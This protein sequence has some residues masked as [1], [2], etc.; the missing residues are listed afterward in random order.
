MNATTC[1]NISRCPGHVSADF[2]QTSGDSDKLIRHPTAPCVGVLASSVQVQDG[3]RMPCTNEGKPITSTT[4]SLAVPTAAVLP[5]DGHHWASKHLVW[6][7]LCPC[8]AAS[9]FHIAINRTMRTWCRPKVVDLRRSDS[10]TDGMKVH[11]Q[12]HSSIIQPTQMVCTYIIHTVHA[13]SHR[14]YHK[15]T[16]KKCK[17]QLFTHLCPEKS[18][19]IF[20]PPTFAKFWPIFDIVSPMD[21]VVKR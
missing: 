10:R 2:Q 14:H 13:A 3:V 16:N 11:S 4:S 15:L 1:Q 8:P 12:W 7:D 5:P 6:K 19:T 9:T 17:I 21:F 20:W 18:A